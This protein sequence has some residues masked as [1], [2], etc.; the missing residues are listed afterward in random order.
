MSVSSNPQQVQTLRMMLYRRPLHPELFKFDHRRA[1]THGEYEVEQWLLKGGHVIR[2]Q[3]GKQC[4]TEVVSG[5]TNH[6]PDLGLVHAL[7]AYG[8]RDYDMP[9]DGKIRFFTTIQTEQLAENIYQATYREMSDFARET[10]SLVTAYQDEAGPC[11]SLLDAQ[12]YKREHHVQSYHLIASTGLVLRTQSIF[13]I[14]CE[15]H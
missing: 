11:L 14:S 5:D 9:T 4:F 7:Q 8:E 3:V 12:K 6:L 13:E 2:F 15:S 1:I 10:G